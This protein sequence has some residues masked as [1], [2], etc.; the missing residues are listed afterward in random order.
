MVIL[1]LLEYDVYK[2]ELPSNDLTAFEVRVFLIEVQSDL[3]LKSVRLEARVVDLR[4]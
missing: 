4:T 3:V 2:G 1:N